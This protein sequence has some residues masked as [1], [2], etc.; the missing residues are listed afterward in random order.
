VSKL[1]V[2]AVE[3]MPLD[4]CQYLYQCKGC[5][6]LLSPMPD[7]CLRVLL[8]RGLDLP[9]RSSVRRRRFGDSNPGSLFSLQEVRM[10]RSCQ[11]CGCG[12]GSKK[13]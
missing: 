12:E 1:R 10:V 5:G 11:S 9:A 6:R 4:A 3:T 13:G 2:S 8:L 7:E